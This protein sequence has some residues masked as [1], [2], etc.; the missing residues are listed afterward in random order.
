MKKNFTPDLLSIL[1]ILLFSYTASSKFLDMN[2]F[3]QQMRLA[4]LPLMKSIAP[5]MGW[6]VP[7]TESIIVITLAIG[8][9]HLQTQIKALYAAVILLCVFE[10]YIAAMLIY[11]SHLP[12]TCGGIISSMGWNVHLFFNGIFIIC[13]GATI[14][15][16]KKTPSKKNLMIKEPK[17][18]S[19]A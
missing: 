9:Y 5:L 14:F 17:I 8:I 7:I 10:V 4:P 6:L 11:G 13:G 18:L 15:Y 19:R 1:L 3:V 2:L 12:C 16:L